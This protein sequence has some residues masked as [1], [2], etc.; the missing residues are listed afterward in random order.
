MHTLQYIDYYHITM[1]RYLFNVL[2]QLSIIAVTCLRVHG[3]DNVDSL[4]KLSTEAL[5]RKGQLAVDKYDNEEALVC[6]TIAAKRYSPDIED[7]E[8]LQTMIANVGKWYIFFFEYYDHVNAFKAISTAHEISKEIG[9]S[10][11]RIMLNYGCMYQTLAEQSEDTELMKK[12][13]DYYVKAF[14]TGLVKDSDM[15]A[16][17]MAFSNLVQVCSILDRTDQLPSLWSSFMKRNQEMKTVSPAFSFDSLFYGVIMK[18]HRKDF[19]GA[20][21]ELD[22]PQMNAIVTQEGMGRYDIVRRINLAKSYIGLTG[23]F[24]KAIECMVQAEAIADSVGMKDARLEVYKYLRDIYEESGQKDKSLEYQHKY[25][26]L[27]DSV[28]NYRSGAAI[29]ELTYLK[30]VEDVEKNLDSIEH[31]RKL[32]ARVIWIAGAII[33]LAAVFIFLLR[34]HNRSLR[35]LNETLYRNNLLLIEKEETARRDLEDALKEIDNTDA[36][37]KPNTVKYQ[38]SDLTEEEKDE[39]YLSIMNVMLNSKEVFEPNFS[40]ARLVE[41]TGH[42]YRHLSQVINEKSG[43]NF[44]ALVNDIRIKEACRGMQSGGRFANLTIEAIANSVGFRSRTSFIA[45]F[46]KFTGLTPSKYQKMAM[47]SK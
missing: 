7:N 40:L 41:L 5:V 26:S 35:M 10:D 11:S 19:A 17:N 4:N 46:K 31:R 38:R 42:V 43:D 30:K 44:S 24:T 14:K 37:V 23:T 20:I 32:Q 12:A 25:L 3:A 36:P 28:L 1:N 27:K 15:S 39:I 16:V 21:T 9:R 29:S 47:E 18:M 45:A 34:R 22:G 2:L 8:K 33:I 13:L 6:F